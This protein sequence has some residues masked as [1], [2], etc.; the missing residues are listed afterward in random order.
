VAKKHAQTASTESMKGMISKG[1]F[2]E[3]KLLNPPSSLQEKY[4]AVF[5]K[6]LC[7]TRKIND[8][9]CT[10]TDLFNSLI[11]RAFRGEL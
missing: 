11:Q 4:G 6:Y 7:M 9:S 1:K 5:E 8:S 10:D 3:V 2:Q